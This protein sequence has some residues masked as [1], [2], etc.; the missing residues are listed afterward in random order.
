MPRFD[1]EL[2]F[3]E[4]FVN[5]LL[6]L[7]C[8][9]PGCTNCVNVR[10]FLKFLCCLR[11]IILSRFG[12]NV[13][14]IQS[15]VGAGLSPKFSLT[16]LVHGGKVMLI[17]SPQESMENPGY[18]GLRTLVKHLPNIFSIRNLILSSRCCN[19]G[20]TINVILPLL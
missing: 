18:L 15:N 16:A 12:S 20:Q 8:G 9:C 2:T 14:C 6:G 17:L 5:C 11:D 3:S 13:C 1:L 7:C 10:P 4:H 19:I